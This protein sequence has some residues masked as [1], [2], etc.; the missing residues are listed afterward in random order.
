[1]E[2]WPDWLL[3]IPQVKARMFVFCDSG[4]E[5][6]GGGTVTETESWLPVERLWEHRILSEADCC[7]L[8]LGSV[9]FVD[10]CLAR[11]S[12]SIPV[13]AAVP[14]GRR[15]HG[16]RREECL[17]WRT[18]KHQDVGGVTTVKCS[19]G[20]SREW[21]E[22]QLRSHVQ[23]RVRH[24][25]VH[26]ERLH[27]L[28]KGAGLKTLQSVDGLLDHRHLDAEF[29]LPLRTCKGEVPRWRSLTTSKIGAAFGLPLTVAKELEKQGLESQFG[30][31]ALS[32]CPGKFLAEGLNHVTACLTGC[33]DP[34]NLELPFVTPMSTIRIRVSDGPKSAAE[35]S[36]PPW[37]MVC[38][39]NA[40]AAKANKAKPNIPMWDLQVQSQRPDLSPEFLSQFHI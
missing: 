7:V 31:Q 13:V 8:L 12:K 36:L 9:G 26:S 2:G 22:F 3:V 17:R 33:S 40:K 6:L 23:R 14:H 37:A 16:V 20:F 38:S 4:K 21:P 15:Q 25:I 35:A 39:D 5:G 10:H 29:S 30:Q 28:G 1:M 27:Y 11:I 19:L 18:L 34:Y 24:V 32:G